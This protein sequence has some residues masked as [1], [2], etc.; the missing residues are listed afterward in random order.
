M[1]RKKPRLVWRKKE[2]NLACIGLTTPK[3]GQKWE[4]VQMRKSVTGG[5]VPVSHARSEKMGY[6]KDETGLDL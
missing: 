2:K 3:N 5:A 4:N 6:G 1:A